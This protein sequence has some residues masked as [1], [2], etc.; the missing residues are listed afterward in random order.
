[1]EFRAI[2]KLDTNQ[3]VTVDFGEACKIGFEDNR[4]GRRL[5]FAA[6]QDSTIIK[7]SAATIRCCP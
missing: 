6:T 5:P 2:V 4:R 7:C 1:M 3:I